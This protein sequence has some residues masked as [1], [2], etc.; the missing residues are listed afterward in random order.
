M[1]ARYDFQ[2][3]TVLVTGAAGGIGQAIVEGLP[4]LERA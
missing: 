2:G 1:S 4:V 3:R